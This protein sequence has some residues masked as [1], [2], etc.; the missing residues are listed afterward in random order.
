MR[1]IERKPGPLRFV[2]HSDKYFYW[3]RNSFALHAE[4]PAM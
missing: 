3:C 1:H 4:T 2:A